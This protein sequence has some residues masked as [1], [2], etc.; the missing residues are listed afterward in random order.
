MIKG[1][2]VGGTEV[3]KM[4]MVHTE[5]VTVSLAFFGIF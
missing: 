4:Y 3:S 2:D 5:V 1:I